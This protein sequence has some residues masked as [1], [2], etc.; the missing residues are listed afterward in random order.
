M[1][2][3]KLNLEDILADKTTEED[4]LE[5]PLSDKIFKS[6][7]LFTILAVVFVFFRFAA[8]GVVKHD[9]YSR[10]AVL[11]MSDTKVEHAPRGIIVDRFG[12]PLLK[13][14]PSFNAYLAPDA[15]PKDLERRRETFSNI[16]GILGVT[17]AD[18]FEKLSKKNWAASPKVLLAQNI[19]HD[20]LVALSSANISGVEIESAFKRAHESSPAF[21]H[22]LGYTG[23]V[24][25]EDLEENSDF[26]LDDDIG[27]TGLEAYYDS[28]LRGIN[29]EEVYLKFASG[30]RKEKVRS[31]PPREGALVETFIDKD[32]QE[33]FYGRLETALRSLG[34]SSGVGIAM[35]P[36]NGELL[37][38]ISI[39]GFEPSNISA[40]LAGRDK[41]LFNRAVSGLYNPGS[42]IKPL[43][44]LAALSEGIIS[45]DQNIFSAGYIEIPNPYNPENPSRFLDWKPHGWVDLYSAIARSSNVYFYEIGGG[46]GSQRGLGIEK[47][48]NWW[49]KFGLS[50]KTG[51]DIVSEKSG[52]LPDPSWKEK[53]TG[54]PWRLGDTYNVSIGQGDLLVTPLELLNYINAIASGGKFFK[55]RIAKNIKNS[56]GEV[57]FENAPQAIGDISE[58][59]GGWMKEVQRAMRDAVSQSY[60]TANL[61]SDLPVSAAGK[62]GSAQVE[63]NAKTNAFFVGYAPYDNPQISIL[64]LVENAREGSLNAVPV[65]RDVLMWYYKNRLK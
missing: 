32:L 38:L 15:L 42:T 40:Y 49:G 16:S 55:P 2:H 7:L 33:Y 31:E 63:N 47:L 25:E 57:I 3:K 1:S 61:L 17:E 19:S 39:P 23:L 18:F 9:F 21:S 50:E 56:A 20:V 10:R 30:N 52:F 64:V 46:F 36:Q 35:N 59:V 26:S 6:F 11:N 45:P 29:G 34:R 62:T 5:V 51:I 53:T 13:N 12:K 60:G 43:H 48:K 41:P 8:L 24:E 54:I 37:A 65:A 4:I 58:D 28:Y 14:K 44:A 27:R 22:V